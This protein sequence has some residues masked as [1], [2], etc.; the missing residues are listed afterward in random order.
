MIVDAIIC[1]IDGTQTVEKREVPDSLFVQP[2]QA[3]EPKQ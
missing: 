2:E 1:H 3:E